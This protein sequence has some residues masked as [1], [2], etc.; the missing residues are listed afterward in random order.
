VPGV[1]LYSEV[2]F[3][4]EDNETTID[5]DGTVFMLGASAAF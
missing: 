5:N 4:D 1:A 2:N 3:I